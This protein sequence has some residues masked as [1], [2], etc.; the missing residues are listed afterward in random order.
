MSEAKFKKVTLDSDQEHPSGNEGDILDSSFQESHTGGPAPDAPRVVEDLIDP[1]L[2][3]KCLLP[4]CQRDGG[5]NHKEAAEE[6]QFRE[7]SC[8]Q[9]RENQGPSKQPEPNSPQPGGQDIK[10]PCADAPVSPAATLQSAD[11]R[12]T[13]KK[14]EPRGSLATERVLEAFTALLAKAG[15]YK[16]SKDRHEIPGESRDTCLPGKDEHGILAA[17]GP[18]EKQDDRDTRPTRATSDA[19]LGCHN[20]EDQN[21][22]DLLLKTLKVY[23]FTVKGSPKLPASKQTPRSLEAAGTRKHEVECPECYKFRGRRCE[24]KY[25]AVC[26]MMTR[27]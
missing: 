21:L 4:V 7:A 11:A 26:G 27:R 6:P 14:S 19:R 24:L 10:V 18:S 2:E 25:A 13:G 20:E 23:G 1:S 22:Q 3:N 5:T 9:N 15:F 16:P 8:N 17:I 12:D